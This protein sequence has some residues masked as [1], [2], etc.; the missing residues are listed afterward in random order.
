VIGLVSQPYSIIPCIKG[1]RGFSLFLM[2][3]QGYRVFL[4]TALRVQALCNSLA[5]RPWVFGDTQKKIEM[6]IEELSGWQKRSKNGDVE[7]GAGGRLER[8]FK[9]SCHD[10]PIFP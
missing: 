4:Y 5:A 7:R 9:L 10:I 8:W 3:D 2:V 6:T 1:Q